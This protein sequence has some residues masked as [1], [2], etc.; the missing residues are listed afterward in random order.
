M[1]YGD[2]LR[3]GTESGADR[4]DESAIDDACGGWMRE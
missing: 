2:Q 4:W 1:K 3:R